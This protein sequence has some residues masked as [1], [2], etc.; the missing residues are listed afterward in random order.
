MQS[1][2]HASRRHTPTT[3][4]HAHMKQ[5]FAHMHNHRQERKNN[6]PRCTRSLGSKPFPKTTCGNP[7]HRGMAMLESRPLQCHTVSN[8]SLHRAKSKAYAPVTTA[9]LEAQTKRRPAAIKSGHG[10]ASMHP[11]PPASTH[12]GH[13][14]SEKQP[15]ATTRKKNRSDSGDPGSDTAARPRRHGSA[16]RWAIGGVIKAHPMCIFTLKGQYDLQ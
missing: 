7:R 10:G 15:G 5:V 13:D 6:T 9:W 8:E 14:A 1:D 11:T 3:A 12:A 16:L 4:T 2:C